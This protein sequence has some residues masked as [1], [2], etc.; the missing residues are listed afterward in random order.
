[1]LLSEFNYELPENL[2]AQYPAKTREQSRM[3][4][5]DKKNTIIQHKNFFEITDYLCKNDVLVLNNTRVIPAR[6]IGQ[7]DTGAKIEV[8]LVEET[9]KDVW[10]VLIK[11]AKRVKSGTIIEFSDKLSAKVLSKESVKMLYNGNF[12]EILSKTGKIPLPPY[13]DRNTN[14][15]DI[16]RYQTIYAKIPGSV[17]AP[18]AGLHFTQ[19]ILDKSFDI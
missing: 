2:I 18:T 9:E 19:E 7:K 12:S 11:P 5:L 1:M 14:A 3:M 8:F 16:D 17:A 10:N 4:I 13:I 6:L 15:E